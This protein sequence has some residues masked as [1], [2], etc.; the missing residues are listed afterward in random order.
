MNRT[1]A[2]ILTLAVIMFLVG[3]ALFSPR[4]AVIVGAL[5]VFLVG[6]GQI[7]VGDRR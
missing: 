5:V 6:V 3:V 1:A 2:T 7:N 4:V